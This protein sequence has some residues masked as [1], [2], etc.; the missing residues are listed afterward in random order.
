MTCVVT[1][2]VFGDDGSGGDGQHRIIGHREKLLQLQALLCLEDDKTDDAMR[3]LSE[4]IRL[5]PEFARAYSS[6][7]ICIVWKEITRRL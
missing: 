1:G 6:R 2:G 3:Q 4:A 5:N 7:G